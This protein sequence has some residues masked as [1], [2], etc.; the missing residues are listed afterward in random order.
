MKLVTFMSG[1]TPRL[2]AIV[3]DRILDVAKAADVM[4]REDCPTS[5]QAL[6]DSGQKGL[7]TVQALLDVSPEKA[8]VTEA[9]LLSPLPSPL[10]LRDCCLFLEHM[11]VS[12]GKIA[13]AQT[14]PG[15]P[16]PTPQGSDGRWLND[17]FYKQVIYYNAD[18]LHVYG[19]DEDIVWP[20]QPGW[21]DYE[22]EWACVVG[23]GGRDISA[24]AAREHIFG[25]TI[26]NDFS[27]R[28]LQIPFMEA[29]LGPA[30]GKDFANSLGPCIVTIDEFA[31]P[32]DLR[33]TARINGQT[34]SSGTTSSM[35]HKFEDA[36]V[37]FSRGRELFAGEVIGS[38]TV[39]GGCGLELDKRLSHGDV[40]ELEVEG[41]G[42][43]RNRVRFPGR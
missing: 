1:S 20:N 18:H 14:K 6:I 27:A 41:I 29:N 4:G 7:I 24:A 17:Q 38:G 32:Y 15:M 36:L 33:M 5:M 40:I 25:F 16:E 28:D 43:L 31:D 39:L 34:W 30:E 13:R 8:L 35:H 12:V 42:I 21:A 11:E 26:F 23:K 10:R 37:Q 9:R 2:G 19:H 3:A 22:L